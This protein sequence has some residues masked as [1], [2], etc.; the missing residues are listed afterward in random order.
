M[1]QLPH[2]DDLPQQSEAISIPI[3]G[4]EAKAEADA[5]HDSGS[6]SSSSQQ[7]LQHPVWLA[8]DEVMDPVGASDVF[9]ACFGAL[10]EVVLGLEVLL[11][12]VLD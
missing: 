2:V 8:L 12:G 5:D 3:A 6:S 7:G 10:L 9:S 1:E 11:G 4:A